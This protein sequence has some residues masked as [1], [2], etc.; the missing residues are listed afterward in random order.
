MSLAG[1]LATEASSSGKELGLESKDSDTNWL[2]EPQ[3]SGECL[4]SP[5][6]QSPWFNYKG[7]GSYCVI[8][9]GQ[10]DTH[11]ASRH[12]EWL[13]IVLTMHVGGHGAWACRAS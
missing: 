7:E 10:P 5:V 8:M 12:R 6:N 1:G 4:E 3:D 2:P 11:K 9:S 13:I